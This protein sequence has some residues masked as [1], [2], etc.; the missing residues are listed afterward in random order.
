MGDW[1]A[2]VD[3]LDKLLHSEGVPDAVRLKAVAGYADI[4]AQADKARRDAKAARSELSV[5]VQMCRHIGT[6][7]AARELGI[8]PRTARWRRQKFFAKIGNGEA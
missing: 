3:R 5:T 7:A 4:L 1:I 6:S 2:E 8:S